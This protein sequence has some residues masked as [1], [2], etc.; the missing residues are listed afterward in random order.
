MSERV[1]APDPGVTR[2]RRRVR[3]GFWIGFLAFVSLTVFL[4]FHVVQQYR[5]LEQAAFAIAQ[6]QATEAAAQINEIFGGVQGIADAIADELSDGTLAYGDIDARMQA[7]LAANPNIDGIAVTFAPYVY[8]PQ[9]RLYQSYNFVNPDGSLGIL[10]GATYDYTSP[11]SDDPDA[12]QTAWYHTPLENGPTWNEPFLATGAQKVLIEYGVPFFQRDQPDTEGGV[13]TIDYSL[14][15]MRD[16]M[17]ALDLGATGYG[18]VFTSSG[19]FLAHPIADYVARTTIFEVADDLQ[20]AGLS[21]GARQALNGSSLSLNDVDPV[22]G[23]ESWVFFEPISVT[24]WALG[25]VMNKAEFLPDA[26]ATLRDQTAIVLAGAASLFFVAALLFHFEQGTTHSLWL[27]AS[28]ASLLCLAVIVVVLALSSTI[29]FHDGVAVT[30]RTAVN[31]YIQEYTNRRGTTDPPLQIPTGVFIQTLDFPDATSV[32]V[33]GYIWQ[34]Y[35]DAL[36]S[37]LAQGFRLAQQFGNEYILEETQRIREGTET[38]VV[39]YFGMTLKQSFNPAQF[40]FDRRNIAIHIVPHDVQHDV[41]LTPDLDSYDL[42]N[43]VLLP[44]VNQDLTI[45]NWR[46]DSSLFSYQVN[47]GAAGRPRVFAFLDQ[48]ELF[49]NINVRRNFVGPLIAYAL[50]GIVAAGLMFAFFVSDPKVGDQEEIIATLSFMAALFFV[51]TVAHTALR[52]SIAAIGITYMEYMYILL[53]LV[54]ILVSINVFVVVRR[55]DIPLFQ[56]RNNLIPKLLFWPLF[57]G[58]FMLATL[59]IFVVT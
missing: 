43:P 27:A 20:N 53:Y 57:M 58:V 44:G 49:Y 24:G 39:W 6:Q 55:P 42:I 26:R 13:V 35:D 40:P 2:I 52:D 31:R 36:P 54:I 28:I 5:Q 34:R 21:D 10:S 46:I 37:D 41:V 9:E 14:A 30:S 32:L 51:I 16:L 48:P 25:I 1:T 4:I 12:P 22:T 56:F 23:E 33:N 7:E 11:P 45:N 50:P 59:G 19:T 18:S 3:V 47:R 15:G 29:R 8:D 38:L 17:A